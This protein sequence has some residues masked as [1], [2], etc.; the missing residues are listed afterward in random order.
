MPC[1]SAVGAN[2]CGLSC[3]YIGIDE[4][5]VDG[6]SITFKILHEITRH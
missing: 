4:K 6:L 3:K 5:V 1:G 2:T